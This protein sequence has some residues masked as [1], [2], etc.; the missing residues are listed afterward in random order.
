MTGTEIIERTRA[1]IRVSSLSP[2]QLGHNLAVAGESFARGEPAAQACQQ[3]LDFGLRD[4]YQKPWETLVPLLPGAIRVG[5][6]SRLEEMLIEGWGDGR[7]FG[8]SPIGAWLGYLR[9]APQAGFLQRNRRSQL[10]RLRAEWSPQYSALLQFLGALPVAPADSSMRYLRHAGLEGKQDAHEYVLEVP[11]DERSETRSES[12]ILRMNSS[13]DVVF[14]IIKSKYLYHRSDPAHITEY[15]TIETGPVRGTAGSIENGIVRLKVPYRWELLDSF[16]DDD[17][18]AFM[19]RVAATH[20][21]WFVAILV[22]KGAFLCGSDHY[23]SPPPQSSVISLKQ[24]NQKASE[25]SQERR[26]IV[27]KNRARAEELRKKYR[28]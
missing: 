8:R 14:C 6:T 9:W 13:D 12:A 27:D 26:S 7:V 23:E 21:P 17:E 19:T 11:V 25:E 5:L 28:R 1:N 18:A 4:A 16:F 24:G 3:I 22:G 10:E 20:Q 2:V 15:S